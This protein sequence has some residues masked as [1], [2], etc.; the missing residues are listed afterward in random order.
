MDLVKK[1]QIT[2]CPRDAM[3]GIR[4]FIPTQLKLDYLQSLL[5]VGFDVL[6]FGS[7]VS[8]KA[9][10]QLA[11]THDI[12]KQ[13]DLSST[14]TKLLSIVA[15]RRGAEDAIQYEQID[16]LGYPFSISETFQKRNTHATLEESLDRVKHIQSI[17]IGANKQLVIYISMGFGNPYGDEWSV[18]ILHHW[19]EQLLDLDIKVFRLSDTIGVATPELLEGLFSELIVNNP[20]L[21]IGAH[22]HSNPISAEKKLKAAIKGGCLMFDGALGGYGGCP[23]AVDKLTGN[24]STS[25]LLKHL[26][27]F[28]FNQEALIKAEKI[29]KEIFTNYF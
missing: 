15:N 29:N 17:C 28:S 12:V 27:S 11:D 13:L 21:Q 1:V 10:P 16:Y 8:P 23:M 4:K 9:I 18:D 24:M 26:P 3:Q 14:S 2:E 20:D 25:L 7:F 5:A 6:D 19:L 22:L